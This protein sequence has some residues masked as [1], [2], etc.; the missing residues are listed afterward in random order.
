MPLPDASPGTPSPPWFTRTVGVFCCA[1]V[2]AG[3]ARIRAGPGLHSV[4][5]ILANSATSGEP[6]NFHLVRCRL[7]GHQFRQVLHRQ[8]AVTEHRLVIPPETEALTLFP[9]DLLPQ[10]V[11]RRPAHEVRRE[12]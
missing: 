1:R 9:L 3:F 4:T 12:L 11:K 5:R 2:V 8:R 10:P 6:G 7:A